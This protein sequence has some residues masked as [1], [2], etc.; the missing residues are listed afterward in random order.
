MLELAVSRGFA[1]TLSWLR[2]NGVLFTRHPA[3]G[4]HRRPVLS[5]WWAL[6]MVQVWSGRF[7][8]AIERERVKL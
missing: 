2:L 1:S 3:S 8:L 7:Q 4:D 5:G 6:V